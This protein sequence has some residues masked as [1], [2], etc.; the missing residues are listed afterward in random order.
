MPAIKRFIAGAVCPRCAAMDTLRSWDHSG[1]R[2]RECVDCDF[3][4]QLA[5]EPTPTTEELATRVNRPRENERDNEIQTVRILDP[6]T[7][8][9]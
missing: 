5:I 1:I 3:L 2:Y 8:R 6:G 7:L 9:R 4:E